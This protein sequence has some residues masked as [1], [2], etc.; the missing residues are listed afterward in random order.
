MSPIQDVGAWPALLGLG[1]PTVMQADV[2]LGVAA[3]LGVAGL[4]DRPLERP[5]P[6]NRGE[7]SSGLALQLPDQLRRADLD[8]GAALCEQP[9]YFHRH[10]R[11]LRLAVAVDRRP[12]HPEPLRELGS[13]RRLIH[14]PAGLQ[15]AV[16]R[17]RVQRPPHPVLAPHPSRH[18]HVGVQLRITGARR[19]VHEPGR[20][21]PVGIDLADARLPCSGERRVLLQIGERGAHGG[22]VGVADLDA[23]VA[24]TDSPQDGHRLRR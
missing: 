23:D 3:D 22:V 6:L 17:P 24:A 19:A 13:K 20:Q 11:D 16:H 8:N 9:A 18:Q 21:Q 10:A 12:R 1:D 14:H 5:P 4:E 2:G 7:R 15:L